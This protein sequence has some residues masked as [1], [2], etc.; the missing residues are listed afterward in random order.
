MACRTD[1]SRRLG[2][3]GMPVVVCLVHGHD[4][5]K[6]PRIGRD[7]HDACAGHC[8][9]GWRFL[10]RTRATVTF[11]CRNRGNTG[12]LHTAC[13]VD[14]PGRFA[15]IEDTMEKQLGRSRQIEKPKRQHLDHRSDIPFYL[16]SNSTLYPEGTATSAPSSLILPSERL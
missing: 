15:K 11:H 4:V 2:S 13:L 10:L 6:R 3:G 16:G 14:R 9:D 12:D 5:R 1:G 7:V 8:D